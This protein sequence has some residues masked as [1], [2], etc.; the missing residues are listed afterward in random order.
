M[1]SKVL[2]RKK[3]HPV[4]AYDVINLQVQAAGQHDNDSDTG[5]SRK[6]SCLAATYYNVPIVAGFSYNLS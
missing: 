5:S 3:L 6:S 4:G 2:S 1:A